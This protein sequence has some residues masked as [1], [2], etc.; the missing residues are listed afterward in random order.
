[1]S[2]MNY[3]LIAGFF[4][5][6]AHGMKRDANGQE[7]WLSK[8]SVIKNGLHTFVLKSRVKEVVITYNKFLGKCSGKVYYSWKKD[9]ELLTNA[10]VDAYL[11]GAGYNPMP[12]LNLRDI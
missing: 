12:H 4:F 10:Q 2:L 1:M 3:I 8:F 6:T 5:S 9:P 7:A 11:K